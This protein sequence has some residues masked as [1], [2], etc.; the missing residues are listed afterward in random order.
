MNIKINSLSAML[1]FGEK[2]GHKIRGGE[3]I[4]LV[5][6]VGA[7]KTTL[8]KGIARGLNIDDDIQSPTF[9]IARVYEARNNLRLHHYDFYRLSEPGI[10]ADELAEVLADPQ[11]VVVIEW[12]AIIGGVLPD[13]RLTIE[14]IADN[15]DSR[16]LVV[17]GSGERSAKLVKALA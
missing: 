10:M 16:K 2:L 17:M 9:T 1:V 15:E 3:V 4:E 5:G 14:I 7:G 6:D 11:A 13:D 8:T 12:A